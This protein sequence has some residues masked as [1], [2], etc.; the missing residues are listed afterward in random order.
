M[1]SVATYMNT[2]DHEIIAHPAER[3]FRAVCL[4]K[5]CFIK[6]HVPCKR[7]FFHKLQGFL[8][9][10]THN[11]LLAITILGQEKS[12]TSFEGH[13]LIELKQLGINVPNVLAC[14]DDYLVIEDCGRSLTEVI[15]GDPQNSQLYLEKAIAALARLHRL[16]QCHGGAQIRNFTLK[17]DRIYLI[18]FE[19][20]I[21][22]E[23]FNDLAFRDLL[24]FLM[25]ASAVLGHVQS[26]PRLI[27]IYEENSRLPVRK[28][29]LRLARRLRFLNLFTRKPLVK[30]MGKDVLT[31]QR[32]MEA[33]RG[34]LEAA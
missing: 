25:S 8:F 30:W 10:I 2:V 12:Q 32:L 17:E 15:K 33:I 7:N 13:K 18:D 3:V 9:K 6:K 1:K 5:P 27:Q 34:Q 11:P 4:E 24:L 29:L 28:R 21:P 16:K 31:M 26:I 14:T 19:E 20:Y 22:E 23:Y